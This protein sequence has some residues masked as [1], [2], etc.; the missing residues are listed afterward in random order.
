MR[1]YRSSEAGLRAYLRWAGATPWATFG[2][3]IEEAVT[4][5]WLIPEEVEMDETQH[6]RAIVALNR[7]EAAG[8]HRRILALTAA[9]HALVMV[10]PIDYGP[11]GRNPSCM[12]CGAPARYRDSWSPP[13]GGA[14][15]V[16]HA[17][18]CAWIQARTL[19]DKEGERR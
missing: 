5:G 12:H 1:T 2:Q 14:F 4:Q 19:L 13:G 15:D 16:D 7:E 18:R 17:P 11:S 3:A 8:A 10:E 9:L 6:L